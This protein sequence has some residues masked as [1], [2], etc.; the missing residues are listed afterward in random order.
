MERY[1]RHIQRILVL[2][3]TLVGT[4][5]G[6]HA[7]VSLR[8]DLI[9]RTSDGRLLLYPFANGKLQGSGIQVGSGFMGMSRYFVNDWTGDSRND[10]IVRQN[11]T[12]LL[13]TFANGAFQGS[14]IQVGHGFSFSHYFVRNW[15]D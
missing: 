9:G 14:G 5:L 3:V 7:Q 4:T 1:R 8:D 12:L 13:Y 11:G 15:I 10:L 2:I 6:T